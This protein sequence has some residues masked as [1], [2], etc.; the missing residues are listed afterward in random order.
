MAQ[1]KALWLPNRRHAVPDSRVAAQSTIVWWTEQ[2][3]EYFIAHQDH[4]SRGLAGVLSM[5]I[6]SF[7]PDELHRFGTLIC[8]RR[9]RRSRR[10]GGEAKISDFIMPLVFLLFVL[11]SNLQALCSIRRKKKSRSASNGYTSYYFIAHWRG[12]PSTAINVCATE[13]IV[14]SEAI[15]SHVYRVAAL[16]ET[17]NRNSEPLNRNINE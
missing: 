15:I 12:I 14:K 10:F 4:L 11:S 2:I 5:T 8:A 17:E 13:Q 9:L 6:A 7:L 16:S 3:Y 1:H